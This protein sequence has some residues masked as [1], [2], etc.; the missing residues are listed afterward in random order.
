MTHYAGP[1]FNG[2]QRCEVCGVKL[3][4]SPYGEGWP[5]GTLIEVSGFGRSYGASRM[6]NNAAITCGARKAMPSDPKHIDRGIYGKDSDYHN[7][8]R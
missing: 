8:R 6:P 1:M 3:N 4:P 5:E 7:G 2:I